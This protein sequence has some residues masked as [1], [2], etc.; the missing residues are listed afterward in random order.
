MYMHG[1]ALKIIENP[2]IEHDVHEP[3]YIKN[4]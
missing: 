3:S 4:T 1:A 2:Y